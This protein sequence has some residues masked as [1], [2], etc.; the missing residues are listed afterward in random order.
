MTSCTTALRQAGPWLGDDLL[1]SYDSVVVGYADCGTYGAL[2]EV[3][4]RR[5]WARMAGLHC[6]DVYAGADRVAAGQEASAGI[7]RDPARSIEI[8]YI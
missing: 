1:S 5:G 2:D 8:A 6:Y 7:D 4:A 3:C